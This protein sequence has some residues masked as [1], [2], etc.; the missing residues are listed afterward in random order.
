MAVKGRHRAVIF[1]RGAAFTQPAEARYI[2]VSSSNRPKHGAYVGSGGWT[3]H[4]NDRKNPGS[5]KLVADGPE[6]I[7]PDGWTLQENGDD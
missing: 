4:Y 1:S 2:D 3:Q 7:M 6:W 5:I